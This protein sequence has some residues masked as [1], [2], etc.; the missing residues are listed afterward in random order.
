MLQAF[1]TVAPEEI[2]L[3]ALVDDHAHVVVRVEP[4]KLSDLQGS[5]TRV[6]NSRSAAPFSPPFAR[7]VTTRSH[8][9]SLV[10]YCLN[11][12]E[13]HGLAD[14]PATATGSCFPDLAGARRIPDFALQ[15]VAALPRFRLRDAY[16]AVGLDTKL[17]PASDEEV[18][19]LGPATLCEVV[20]RTF[21]VGPDLSGNE[22]VVAQARRV[23]AKLARDTGLRPRDLAEAL[24]T[25]GDAVARMAKRPVAEADLKAVRLRIALEQAAATR[26]PAVVSEPPPPAY[27]VTRTV[28]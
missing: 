4:A 19:R 13:H 10:S 26:V 20:A 16:T 8:L 5:L 7:P 17:V 15:I 6:L 9:E 1:A 14:D 22:A 23:A 18:R 2:V 25:T 21:A 12:F 3:F 28:N 27:I 11:Q 24:H